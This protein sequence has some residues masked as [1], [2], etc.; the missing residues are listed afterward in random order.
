MRSWL[1]ACLAVAA[2]I[3]SAQAE[4]PAA[5]PAPS[6]SLSP[7]EAQAVYQAVMETAGARA[8]AVLSAAQQRA[9]K[10]AQSEQPK[11]GK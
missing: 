3:G 8:L 7:A 6:I 10:A 9:I 5:K 4:P 2:L 1:I 11:S